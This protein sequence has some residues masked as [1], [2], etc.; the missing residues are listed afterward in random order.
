MQLVRYELVYTARRR[1]AL[2]FKSILSR[3]VVVV[4]SENEA[5]RK[6]LQCP[7][8]GKLLFNF[9]TRDEQNAG[10]KCFVA[11]MPFGN[12]CS[13]QRKATVSKPNILA[14]S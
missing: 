14:S 3:V 7:I 10:L 12:L 13:P 9:E 8:N 1:P 4:V 5:G 2:C 6:A 11:L